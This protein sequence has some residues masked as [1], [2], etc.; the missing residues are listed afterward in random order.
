MK[1]Q[2]HWNEMKKLVIVFSVKLEKKNFLINMI[3]DVFI[4]KLKQES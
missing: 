4:S 3:K 1:R 2:N